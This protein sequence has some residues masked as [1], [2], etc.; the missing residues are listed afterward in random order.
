MYK[1]FFWKT[2]FVYR[3]FAIGRPV[4]SSKISILDHGLNHLPGRLPGHFWIGKN[5]T[6]KPVYL[7]RLCRWLR[8]NI[9]SNFD[10]LNNLSN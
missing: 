4:Q 6:D 8:F 1:I 2:V 7:P 10:V 9:R 5:W 3:K